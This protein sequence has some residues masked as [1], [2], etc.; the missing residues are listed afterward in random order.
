MH[1]SSNRR[2]KAPPLR[3]LRSIPSRPSPRTASLGHAG[4]AL[5]RRRSLVAALR[6]ASS[7]FPP[8]PFQIWT[9]RAAGKDGG[10]AKPKAC[11]PCRKSGSGRGKEPCNASLQVRSAL[12]H[13]QGSRATPVV[14]A[15][16]RFILA[17]ERST[18]PRIVRS[19]ARPRSAAKRRAGSFRRG[20]SMRRTTLRCRE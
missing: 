17:N 9:R 5:L 7:P 14:A 1:G 13:R 2:P 15:N 3:R 20:R 6:S 18:T 10:V 12:D 11:A 8:S 4:I 19:I 16:V